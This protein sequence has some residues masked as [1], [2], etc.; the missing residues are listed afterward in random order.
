MIVLI[1]RSIRLEIGAH[2]DTTPVIVEAVRT[3]SGKGKLGGGL[4][5][6]H[7]ADL[8]AA[9]L[10]QLVARTGIDAGNVDDVIAGCVTQGGEQGGN[11]ARSAV[12]AAG[13]PEH[14]PGTSVDRQCGSS[15]QAVHFAAQGVAAGAYDVVIACGVELMS[16]TPMFSQYGKKDPYG[17]GVATRYRPGLVQ[18]GLSAELLCRDYGFA[19]ADLDAFAAESH[20]RAAATWDAGGFDRETIAVNGATRDET[21]RPGTTIERLAQL[22]PAFRD[23]GAEQR[24]GPIDWMIT[25]GNASPYTDGA[26][27]LLI[28]SMD[29]AKRLGLRPRAKFKA[30]SVV[31]DDPIRMLRGVVPATESVLKRARM[32][33]AD[34]DYFEV[35]EAFAPVP[36]LW[37]RDIGVEGERL[38]PRGGA[39]A[40]GHPLGASGTRLMTTL[41][42]EL[43]DG[44]KTFGLQ[45]MCEAGGM[46]NATI[47]ERV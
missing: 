31:G 30:F 38:N 9:V 14:V 22:P 10:Q 44:D 6:V 18:Q 28:M 42:H 17:P 26:S 29:A 32:A 43:E 39:I 3:T 5:G 23:P 11:I 19:R 12:L 24:F 37:A 27:G 8:L 13:F 25:A 4:S 47:I 1:D 20:R 34:I 41:L 46:A 33:P 45:T 35:N 40:L 16:R 15:Q 36:M 7:A 21:V 2:V